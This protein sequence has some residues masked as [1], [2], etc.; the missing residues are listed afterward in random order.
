MWAAAAGR[1]ARNIA[2]ATRRPLLGIELDP[3]R[4]R[5]AAMRLSEVAEVDVEE[6]PLPFGD[7]PIDCIV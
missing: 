2:A 1:W 7:G 3:A 6:Q 4:A 5:L